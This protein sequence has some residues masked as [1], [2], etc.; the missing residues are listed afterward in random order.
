MGIGLFPSA[1]AAWA[2]LC[3]ELLV[4]PFTTAASML[5]VGLFLYELSPFDFVKSTNDLHASFARAHWSFVNARM[6]TAETPPFAALADQLS[7]TG[8]FAA[9]GFL[10]ALGGRE[11]GRLPRVSLGSALKDGLILATLVEFM[12]L[13]TRSHSFD[14]ATI[15]LRSIGV[16]FGA[17]CALFVIDFHTRSEWRRS[18]SMAF[19]TGVMAMLF[20]LQIALLMAPYVTTTWPSLIGGSSAAVDWLPF[21]SLWRLSCHTAIAEMLSTIAIYGALSLTLGVLLRR[22]QIIHSTGLVFAALA[23]LVTA[24]EGLRLITLDKPMRITSLILAMTA[25]YLVT[26]LWTKVRPANAHEIVDA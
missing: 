20:V 24:S 26:G 12:Q 9:L 2:Q 22:L 14:T 7:G 15:I 4:H 17:W 10:A 1:K 21:E 23:L 5:T 6:T 13:L 8:W 25:A 3:G 11:R 16:V 18:P 19:P